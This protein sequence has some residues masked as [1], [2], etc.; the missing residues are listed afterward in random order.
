MEPSGIEVMF[1]IDVTTPSKFA[2]LTI[3]T[4]I[5]PFPFPITA[6]SKIN[7]FGFSAL[8]KLTELTITATSASN[9]AR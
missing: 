3:A 2:F 8:T 1:P 7:S 6:P 4:S 9:T 5:R